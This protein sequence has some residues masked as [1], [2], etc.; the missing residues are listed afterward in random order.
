MPKYLVER[1]FGL[2]SDDE[3]DEL[4]RNSKR[5]IIDQFPDVVWHHSH[6]VVDA[7]GAVR[8]FC[9]YSAPNED[10]VRQHA[11]RVGGHAIDEIHQIA[12]DVDPDE[13]FV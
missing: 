11:A 7:D 4:G 9:I 3:M 12:G 8:S 5:L 13:I 10:R 2:K 6:V 1:S